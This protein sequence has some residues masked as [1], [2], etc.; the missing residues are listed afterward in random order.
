MPVYR[1]LLLGLI[2]EILPLQLVYSLKFV[3]ND[4]LVAWFLV[5]EG[6]WGRILL[7]GRVTTR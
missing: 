7:F 1:Q 2:E 6:Y 3:T 5:A 4:H